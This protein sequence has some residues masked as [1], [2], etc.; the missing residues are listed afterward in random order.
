MYYGIVNMCLK[1]IKVALELLLQ[2]GNHKPYRSDF[3]VVCKA[4][5]GTCRSHYVGSNEGTSI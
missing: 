5:N 4:N 2:F 1:K 3:H